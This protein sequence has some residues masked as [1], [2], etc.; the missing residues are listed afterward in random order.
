M[1]TGR[2]SNVVPGLE[3]APAEWALGSGHTAGGASPGD[4]PITEP[5]PQVVARTFPPKP[6]RARVHRDYREW[7][8]APWTDVEPDPSYAL[9][10][11]AL[12]AFGVALL[13][14]LAA[15]IAVVTL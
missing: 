12:L 15:V 7:R 13:T 9:L 8:D 4:D 5:F 1:V 14:A 6:P 10:V 11:V 2:H 3:M